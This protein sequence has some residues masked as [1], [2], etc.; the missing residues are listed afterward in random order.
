[1]CFLFFSVCTRDY[2][3]HIQTG[4]GLTVVKAPPAFRMKFLLLASACVLTAALKADG[5]RSEVSWRRSGSTAA[6][7]LLALN[8]RQR[9]PAV[10]PPSDGGWAAAGWI[11]GAAVAAETLS[12]LNTMVVVVVLRRITGVASMA[13][14]AERIVRWFHAYGTMAYPV[15]ASILISMQVCA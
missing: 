12:I 10:A 8:L 3:G 9:A 6:P 2:T 4:P 13:E 7:S 11:G 5:G 15:Y 14:L 1:M